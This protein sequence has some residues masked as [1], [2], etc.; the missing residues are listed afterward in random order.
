LIELKYT[1]KAII[2]FGFVKVKIKE[3]WI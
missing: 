1:V 3:E 2:F